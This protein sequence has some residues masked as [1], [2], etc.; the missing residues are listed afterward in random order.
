[1][2]ILY[3]NHPFQG[4]NSVFSILTKLYN[5]HHCLNLR[6]FLSL[7]KEY[8]CALLVTSHGLLASVSGNH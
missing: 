8:P 3:K 4:H 7:Q 1:M 2:H 6:I 5:H